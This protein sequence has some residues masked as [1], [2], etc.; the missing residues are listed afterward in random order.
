[1]PVIPEF[2]GW[3]AISAGGQQTEPP[4]AGKTDRQ[5]KKKVGIAMFL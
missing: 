5:S 4:I 3:H 2:L 1:M